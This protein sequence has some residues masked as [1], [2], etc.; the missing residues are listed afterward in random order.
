MN[1]RGFRRPQTFQHQLRINER[2]RAREVLVID[3][4]GHSLGVMDPRQGTVEARKVGLDLVEVSPRANP[5]VCKILDFGK[6]RYELAKR[7]KE[8]RKHQHANKVKEIKF[9]I[10]I[11]SNDYM[12]KIRRAEGFLFKG[13]KVK[14]LLML[15]GREMQ[16]QGDGL[17]LFKRVIADLATV[18]APDSDPKIIGKNINLMLSP[19]PEQKRARKF[20]EDHEPLD[21][22]EDDAPEES[23]DGEED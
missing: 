12:V 16:R 14:L 9:R 5:P 19:L 18:G 4:E 7:E 10:N 17:T 8:S 3:A 1:H 6:Y 20:T 22:D 21:E 13:L 11:D 2:I 23:G 15:R